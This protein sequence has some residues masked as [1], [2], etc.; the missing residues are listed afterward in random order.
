VTDKNEI[1]EPDQSNLQQTTE[2]YQ[3]TSGNDG[4]VAGEGAN[5]TGAKSVIGGLLAALYCIIAGAI[6]LSGGSYVFFINLQASYVAVAYGVVAAIL[7][8]MLSRK[9]SMFIYLL[10]RNLCIAFAI[11]LVVFFFSNTGQPSV[12]QVLRL[13]LQL[14]LIWIIFSTC[15]LTT[16]FLYKVPGLILVIHGFVVMP[17]RLARH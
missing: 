9:F 17:K 10:G 2:E 6:G 7:L 12:Q 15:I 16:T 8:V 4:E 3:Q 5:A 13:V 14:A 1:P 11:L